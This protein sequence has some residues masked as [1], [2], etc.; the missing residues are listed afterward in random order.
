MMAISPLALA[1]ESATTT[2]TDATSS[3]TST[4]IERGQIRATDMKGSDVYNSQDKKIA[5]IKDMIVNPDGRIAAVVLDVDGKYVAVG[6]RALTLAINDKKLH[7]ST[8]M[9]EQQLK[10]RGAFDLDTK[11]AGNG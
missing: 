5:S 1:A 10:S 8:E 3:V 4:R 11:P 7:I 2:T 9:S 6:M